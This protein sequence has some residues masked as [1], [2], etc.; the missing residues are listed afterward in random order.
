MSGT[1]RTEDFNA[2]KTRQLNLINPDGSFPAQGQ[3]IGVTDR[4]GSLGPTPN[5]VFE[6]VTADTLSVINPSFQATVNATTVVADTVRT[7]TLDIINNGRLNVYDLCANRIGTVFLTA[8]DVSANCITVDSIY[9]RQIG[10][11]A[12]PANVGNFVNV[13]VTDIS[14]SQIRTSNLN[15]G[16][17]YATDISSTRVYAQ[18][19][20]TT[21]L[22]AKTISGADSINTLALTAGTADISGL[23]VRNMANISRLESADISSS[24]LT[25]R[26]ALV[27]GSLVTSGIFRPANISTVTSFT[28]RDISATNIYGGTGTFNKLNIQRADVDISGY[29]YPSL[30][31]GVFTGY[32]INAGNLDVSGT[33]TLQTTSV[34]TSLSVTGLTT[35]NSLVA[36]QQITAPIVTATSSLQVGTVGGTSEITMIDKTKPLSNIPRNP[37][38]LTYDISNGLLLNGLLVSSNAAL[39]NTRPFS[40]VTPINNLATIIDISATMFDLIASYNAF[41]QIFN[42]AKII[43]QLTPVIF[44]NSPCSIQ[45]DI[46]GGLQPPLIL[47]GRYQLTSTQGDISTLTGILTAAAKNVIRFIANQNPATGQWRVS[48]NVVNPG[49]NTFISDISGLPTGSLQVLRTIGFNVP[50][51][52]PNLYEIYELNGPQTE[53]IRTTYPLNPGTSDGDVLPSSVAYP[54]NLAIPVYTVSGDPYSLPITF[55][56]LI[57]TN[58]QYLAIKYNGVYKLYP[59]TNRTITFTG[60]PPN[61]GY[62]FIFNYLDQYNN[63]TISPTLS[64]TKIP[65]PANISTN[66][67]TF[68]S[69]EVAWSQPY[70]GKT[71]TFK[72]DTSGN[73]ITGVPNYV[74]TSIIFSSLLRNSRYLVTLTSYEAAFTTFS[75]PA[76]VIIVDTPDLTVPTPVI[77]DISNTNITKQVSWNTSVPTGANGDLNYAIN[78]GG[79]IRYAIPGTDISYNIDNLSGVGDISC[80]LLYT[81]NSYNTVQGSVTTFRYDTSFGYYDMSATSISISLDDTGL[82]KGVGF[83][84]PATLRLDAFT[85]PN[86]WIGYTFNRLSFT[87]GITETTGNNISFRADIY[88]VTSNINDLYGTGAVS[89]FD[90]SNNATLIM[91]TP[92]T[93]ISGSTVYPTLTF[94]TPIVISSTTMILFVLT[95]SSTGSLSFRTFLNTDPINAAY[96][97]IAYGTSVGFQAATLSGVGTLNNFSSGTRNAV[98]CQFSYV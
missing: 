53:Y 55:T 9:P 39:A 49:A 3:L 73:Y 76:P 5:P 74:G 12:Q 46:C 28:A 19:I 40:I 51:G 6:H 88:N 16:A 2:V 80:S 25:V 93:D 35:T 27:T 37:G 26:D 75:N 38:I 31:A 85:G 20:T 60:L 18:Q 47:S 72:I 24:I 98:I 64:T 42:D 68:N 94:P 96:V 90:L 48:I 66:S 69:F 61:T 62:P 50:T 78:N 41:L 57:G 59:N 81:D 30:S 70:Q 8:T 17:L 77:R 71:Y 1:R 65:I 97:K 52:G 67:V 13:N 87:Q 23:T 84:F 34:G 7:N 91:S 86:P 21:N 79:I 22:A 54:N 58:V 10:S 83:V 63:S 43:I 92:N 4:Y 45:F 95:G 29:Y 15:V 32:T 33:T 11:G 89:P 82:L 14:A 56:N 44:F 36:A